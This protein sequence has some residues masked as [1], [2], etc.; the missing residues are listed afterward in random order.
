MYNQKKYPIFF[1]NKDLFYK[2]LLLKP[3]SKHSN[4]CVYCHFSKG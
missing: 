1:N 2:G 3:Y 4:N